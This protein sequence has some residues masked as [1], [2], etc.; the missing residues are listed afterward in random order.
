MAPMPKAV[1]ESAP[2]F[3]FKIER[4]S[5]GEKVKISDPGRER[6]Y[7]PLRVVP[8]VALIKD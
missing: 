3:T 5:P 8:E 1:I 2:T 6:L 4:T 7:F